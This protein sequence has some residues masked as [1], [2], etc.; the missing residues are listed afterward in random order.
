ME[1]THWMQDLWPNISHYAMRDILIP[2]THNS[3][4]YSAGN[5]ILVR[6]QD[7]TIRGQLDGGIR[8]FDIRVAKSIWDGNYVMHHEGCYP[9]DTSQNLEKALQDMAKFAE[10][11]PKEIFVVNL[12]PGSSSNLAEADYAGLRDFVFN[13]LKDYLVPEEMATAT[14]AELAK[15]GKRIIILSGVGTDKYFWRQSSYIVSSW[16][17]YQSDACHTV[18]EK[19]AFI[20]SNMEVALADSATHFKSI[21]CEMGG[22]N[23][24]AEADALLAAVSGKIATLWDSPTHKNNMNVFTVD[25]FDKHSAIFIKTLLERN[26]KLKKPSS[27]NVKKKIVKHKTTFHVFKPAFARTMVTQ[28][29][30]DWHALKQ[31]YDKNGSWSKASYKTLASAGFSKEAVDEFLHR[32]AKK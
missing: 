2:A 11:H 30:L 10:E 23:V 26:E 32:Y 20:L 15:A 3:G 8:C 19:T 28:R 12:I 17:G 24:A 6:C 29:G 9:S 1:A 22:V 13:P 27:G 14:L 5:T 21:A 4:A 16:N 7:K 18:P 25:F 31:E